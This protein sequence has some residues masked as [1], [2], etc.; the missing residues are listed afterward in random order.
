MK[1]R[2]SLLFLVLVLMTVVLCSCSDVEIPPMPVV[3]GV[4]EYTS[5]EELMV[6]F[7]TAYEKQ[8]FNAFEALLHPDFETFLTAETRAAFPSVG[9]TLDWSEETRIAERM[10]A[11]V[12]VADPEGHHVAGISDFVFQVMDQQSGWADSGPGAVIPNAQAAMFDVVIS[13]VRPTDS[14][15]KVNGQIMFFVAGRDT[16]INGVDRTY[17]TMLGQ[18]DLTSFRFKASESTSWGSAK[19]L[20]R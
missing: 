7:R 2:F 18:Q 14:F 9:P 15:M 8:D 12:P 20:Y 13:I 3:E 19:A 17:W 16:V 5:P 1:A 4:A 6:A 10:F 11:G